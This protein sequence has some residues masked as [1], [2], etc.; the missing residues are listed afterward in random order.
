MN[1]P[2]DSLDP[3][4][5]RYVKEVTETWLSPVSICYVVLFIHIIVGL[6][7]AYLGAKKGQWRE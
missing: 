5:L 4:H 6:F 2:T 3:K 7:F 1:D